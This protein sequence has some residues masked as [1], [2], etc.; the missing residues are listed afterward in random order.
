MPGK[1]PF[2]SPYTRKS[3]DGF[4]VSDFAVVPGP[5][6]E[7]T[8]FATIQPLS[9]REIRDLP[10]GLRTRAKYSC[11]TYETLKVADTGDDFPDLVVVEGRDFEVHGG[12]DDGRF[13]GAPIPGNDYVLAD[14]EL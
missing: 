10:E 4:T 9:A 7:S 1:P 3:R 11:F 13:P 5:V 8:I 6:T 12:F 14:P 2:S